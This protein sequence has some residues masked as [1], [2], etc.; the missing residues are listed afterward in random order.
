MREFSAAFLLSFIFLFAGAAENYGQNPP[1]PRPGTGDDFFNLGPLGAAGMPMK[2]KESAAAGLGKV[3]AIKVMKV[4]AKGSAAGLLRM[5]DFITAAAG[6]PFPVREDPLLVLSRA[7]E[8]AEG[9]KKPALKLQVYRG[10]KPETVTL[11]VRALGKHSRTC[12]M[13]CKKCGVVVAESLAFLAKAQQGDGS[14][15]GGAGGQNA[16]V[17]ITTLSGL[18]FLAS[19]S[20][21][22]AG[23]HATPLKK[24]VNYLLRCAGKES[25]W[26]TGR[27]SGGG[28]WCQVNWNAGYAPWF[29]AE[30]YKATGDAR[31][32]KKVTEL[33]AQIVKNQERSGGWAHGPGGPNALGYLELEIVSN[34]CLTA[35]GLAKR[36]GVEVDEGAIDRGVKY[37]VACSGGDGGIG[38]STR[39]GQKS[40]GDPG[41]TAGAVVAF[42]ALGLDRHPFFPKMQAYYRR[43]MK[44]LVG[45]HVSPCMHFLAG[46]LAAKIGGPKI[47]KQYWERFRDEIM[48]ARRHDGSFSARPTKESQQLHRNTD[49]GQGPAWITAHYV[50]IMQAPTAKWKLLAK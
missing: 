18:A 24:A 20:T 4:E 49:R 29:L 33:A 15:K 10:G 6:R 45:G 37:V 13:K 25:S 22:K 46:S 11:P 5:G 26:K 14:W 28:N 48:L 39:P 36:L 19:G 1:V 3:A 31:L 47:W 41:R 27:S 38:Y 42:H 30:A 23:P 17:V 35:L 50:L 9:A 40:M 8:A 44:H 43:N 34:Y 12:P 32:L 21:P 16:Q 2:K 7:I